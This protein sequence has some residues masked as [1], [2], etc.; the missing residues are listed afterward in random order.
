MMFIIKTRVL[1]LDEREQVS[2][3]LQDAYGIEEKAITFET[4]SSTVSNE[5]RTDAV[6]AVIDSSDLYV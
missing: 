2:K 6:I 1:S 3:A 4:I 5:M